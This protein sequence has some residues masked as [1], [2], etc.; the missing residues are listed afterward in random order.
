MRL[1]FYRLFLIVVLCASIDLVLERFTFGGASPS[2]TVCTGESCNQR[3]CANSGGDCPQNPGSPPPGC[4]WCDGSGS[5]GVCIGDSTPGAKCTS[6]GAVGGSCGYNSTGTCESNGT[7]G[8]KV[9]DPNVD[10]EIT[11]C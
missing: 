8:T 1:K 3:G 4:Y 2:G 7:C 11:S 6:K 9:S 5:G 10:C